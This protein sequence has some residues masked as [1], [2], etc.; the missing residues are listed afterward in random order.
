MS[1]GKR[2]PFCLALIV[3]TLN[4]RGPSYLGLTISISWLLMPWL[5]TSPG[6]QQPWYW[7]YRIRRSFSYLRKRF[8]YLCEINVEEWHKIQIYVPSEKFT[9]LRV[10]AKL[11][12]PWIMYLPFQMTFRP[13]HIGCYRTGSWVCNHHTPPLSP[14][15]TLRPSK[16]AAI[17]QTTFPNAFSW[18]KMYEFCLRFH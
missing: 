1:S 14:F 18:M 8:R 16:I 7:L 9:T 11:W 12:P 10:K 17:L 4:M 13:C 5:L 3:L 15:N 2:L 6:H